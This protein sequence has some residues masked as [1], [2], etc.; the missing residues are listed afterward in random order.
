MFDG[1]C[2]GREDR[3]TPMTSILPSTTVSTSPF[4]TPADPDYKRCTSKCLVSKE[5]KPMCGSDFETY[6]NMDMVIC[7]Q[8]C[9]RG[10]K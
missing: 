4:P 1:P 9:G 7:A 6:I 10:K 3:S 2:Q 8:K 5:F